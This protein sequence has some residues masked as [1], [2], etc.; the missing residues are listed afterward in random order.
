[1]L[2]SAV[3]VLVLSNISYYTLRILVYAES[4]FLLLV[5]SLLQ[6]DDL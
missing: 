5:Y 1:M 2:T 3:L 4:F 6:T